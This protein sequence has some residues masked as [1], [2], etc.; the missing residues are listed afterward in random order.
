MNVDL[1]TLPTDVEALHA[2]VHELASELKTKELL[3]A[4]LEARIAKLKR[5]QFGQLF[6]A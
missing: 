3:N 5:L 6:A 2:L 4:Q 1:S